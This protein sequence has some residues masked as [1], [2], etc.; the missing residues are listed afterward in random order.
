M[1]RRAAGQKKSTEL[2]DPLKAAGLEPKGSSANGASP[3]G[4]LTTAPGQPENSNVQEKGTGRVLKSDEEKATEQI[5]AYFTVAQYD[6]IEELQRAY[7][8]KAKKRITVN[9]LLR[10]LVEHATVEDIL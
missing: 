6:K 7:R 9:A 1:A 2:A 4:G 3:A 10:R 5:T 8:K